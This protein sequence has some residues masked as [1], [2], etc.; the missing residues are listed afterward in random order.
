MFLGL[1]VLRLFLLFGWVCLFWCFQDLGLGG[2]LFLWVCRIFGF[3]CI[4]YFGSDTIG[5]PSLGELSGF[6]GFCW[7][8]FDCC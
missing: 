5:F 8:L 2:L 4:W 3:D 1:M 7:F 6:S